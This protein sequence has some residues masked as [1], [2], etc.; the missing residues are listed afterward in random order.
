M[1]DPLTPLGNPVQ[2]MPEGIGS[3]DPDTGAVQQTA[4]MPNV[5]QMATNRTHKGILPNICR[6]RD[7]P[8]RIHSSILSRTSSRI[9]RCRRETSTPGLSRCRRSLTNSGRKVF[10]SRC[11]PCRVLNNQQ[12]K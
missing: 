11:R 9:S 12:L 10:N 4:A 8:S 2:N 1:Q 3:A 5:A 6:S 7:M